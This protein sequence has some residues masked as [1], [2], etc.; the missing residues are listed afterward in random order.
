MEYDYEIIV[1]AIPTEPGYPGVDM[2][3]KIPAIEVA[4]GFDPRIPLMAWAEKAIE[5]I[6]RATG[7]IG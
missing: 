5:E 2:R 4:C 1:R 6:L 3:V 7:R